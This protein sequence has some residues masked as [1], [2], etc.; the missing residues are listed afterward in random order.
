MDTHWQIGGAR[1]GLSRWDGMDTGVDDGSGGG[2]MMVGPS[3]SDPADNRYVDKDYKPVP[4]A[5]L[6][7]AMKSPMGDAFFAVAKRVPVRFPREDGS[8][9]DR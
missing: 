5:K 6:R 9:Q 8:I 2:G 4:A 1:C 3:S 7:E